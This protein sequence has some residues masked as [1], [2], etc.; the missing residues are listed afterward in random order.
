MQWISIQN[1]WLQTRK[2]ENAIT[3]LHRLV[4]VYLVIMYI[5]DAM[6]ESPSGLEDDMKFRAERHIHSVTVFAPLPTDIKMNFDRTQN[7][8][9][10]THLLI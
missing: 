4:L 2:L 3:L 8:I 9:Y 6:T 1:I 5:M 10:A 7:D